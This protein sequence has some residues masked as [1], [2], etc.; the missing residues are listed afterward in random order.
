MHAPA[1]GHSSVGFLLGSEPTVQDPIPRTS[2]GARAY[3]ARQAKA[4][5]ISSRSVPAA[6]TASA[7]AFSS[8]KPLAERTQ[9]APASTETAPKVDTGAGYTRAIGTSSNHWASG[10]SQNSGNFITDRPTTRLSGPP[11][12]ASRIVLG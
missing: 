8:V 12:G 6:A 1:G 10:S 9:A 5:A 4:D 3:A 2:A 7:T 11:G